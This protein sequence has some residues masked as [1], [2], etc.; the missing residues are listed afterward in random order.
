MEQEQVNKIRKCAVYIFDGFADHEIALVMS[1][2]NSCS[3]FAIETFS[4]NGQVVTS[5]SGLKVCPHTSLKKMDPDFFDLL[6]LPGGEQWEK[7]DNLDIFPLI[8]DTIGKR[9]VAAICGATLA[10]ADLGLLDDISHTSNF[11]GYI[12]RFCPDYTGSGLYQEDSCVNTGA[13]I[14]AN[15]VAIVDL[16]YEIL[17]TFGIFKEE[18]ARNWKELYRSGGQVQSFFEQ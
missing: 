7:G 16:A 17:K 9:P 2:L 3:D 8:R 13:V 5:M 18:Q 14:T 11:P 4:A 15:G 6:L 10:L 1:W 12:Q